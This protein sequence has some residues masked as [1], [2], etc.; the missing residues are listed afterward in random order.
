MERANLLKSQNPLVGVKWAGEDGEKTMGYEAEL[1]EPEA[2]CLKENAPNPGR[3]SH[4]LVLVPHKE[5]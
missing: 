1:G 3:W 2:L 4:A 5:A